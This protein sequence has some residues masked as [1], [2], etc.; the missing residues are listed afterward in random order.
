[1]RLVPALGSRAGALALVRRLADELRDRRKV[2]ATPMWQG[3]ERRLPAGVG[4][5]AAPAPA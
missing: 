1:M 5:V 4:A 3:L 2:V